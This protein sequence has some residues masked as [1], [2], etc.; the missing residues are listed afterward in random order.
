MVVV[1]FRRPDFEY[2]IPAVD[3]LAGTAMDAE[4]QVPFLR[5]RKQRFVVKPVD[6]AGAGGP[7]LRRRHSIEVEGRGWLCCIGQPY[8]ELVGKKLVDRLHEVYVDVGDHARRLDP[9]RHVMEEVDQQRQAQ[10]RQRDGAGDRQVRHEAALLIDAVDFAQD[11]DAI[12]E[13]GEECAQHKLNAFVAHEV[14]QQPGPELAG[15]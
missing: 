6:V 4:H 8:R 14:A 11:E 10:R 2:A 5:N 1:A 3:K 13:R 9:L 15:R 7:D 12:E